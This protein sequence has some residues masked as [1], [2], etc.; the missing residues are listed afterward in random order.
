MGDT[1]RQVSKST[2]EYCNSPPPPPPPASP[3][4]RTCSD[5]TDESL[6]NPSRTQLPPSFMRAMMAPASGPTSA[7][8]LTRCTLATLN[9]PV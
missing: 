9:W 1:D 8:P 4:P 7:L 6:P 5:S 2:D 3:P